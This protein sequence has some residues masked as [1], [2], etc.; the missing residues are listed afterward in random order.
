M[1]IPVKSF[2]PGAAAFVVATILFLL[3]G[4]EFPQEDWFDKI[5]LD[6][7]IHIGLF[8][9]LVSLWSLP[10]IYRV[11][12]PGRL[13]TIFLWVAVGFV[14]YGIAIEFIQGSFIPF[15]TFGV[16]D[17]VADAVGCGIGFYFARKQ[18]WRHQRP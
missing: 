12:D 14:C 9:G 7:W 15:R 1:K 16:D 2:W 10:F 13:L 18:M 5:F 3:P 8:A 6:K 17:M 4:Q 11:K